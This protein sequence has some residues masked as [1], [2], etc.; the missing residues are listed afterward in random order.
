MKSHE[1]S[2][3]DDNKAIT[4][5]EFVRATLYAPTGS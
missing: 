5:L 4:E 2:E 3:H 1:K